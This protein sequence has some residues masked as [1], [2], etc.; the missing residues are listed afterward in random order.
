M[1]FFVGFSDLSCVCT[2]KEAGTDD[3]TR[4]ED[5]AKKG[6]KLRCGYMTIEEQMEEDLHEA[7]EEALKEAMETV[8]RGKT[9]HVQ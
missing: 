4:E 8:A 6:E 5:T 3:F 9:D 2:L 1:H 7:R